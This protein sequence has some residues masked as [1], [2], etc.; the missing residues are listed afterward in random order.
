M[1]FQANA[2]KSEDIAKIKIPIVKILFLFVKSANLP[3][4][5]DK[6]AAASI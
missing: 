5:T 2:E 6:A 3:K 1:I 4:G